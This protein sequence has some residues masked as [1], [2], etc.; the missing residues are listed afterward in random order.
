[1]K[2]SG[3]F[4]FGVFGILALVGICFLCLSIYAEKEINKPKFELPEGPPR[5]LRELPADK[6]EA[7]D[8]VSELYNSIISA[9]DAEATRHT[10]ISTKG[11]KK[12][13]LSAADSEVLSRVLER[14]Q[15]NIGSLYPKCENVLVSE[16]NDLPA[17]CFTKADVVDF[18]ASQGQ[19]DENGNTVDD[20]CYFITLTL[21]P[22]CVDKDAILY[23]DQ[24]KE[25]EKELSSVLRVTS[26]D[27]TVK[28]Y[29]ARF[30]INRFDDYIVHAELR[31]SLTIKAAVDFKDDFK[32][33]CSDTAQFE[34]PYEAADVL[35]FLRYGIRF[36]DDQIAVRK[37]DMK[38][39]PLEVRV[40]SQ[41]EKSDYTLEFD[42]SKDGIL[43]IDDDGVMT[44]LSAQT[45]PL[46]VT[47]TLNYDGHVY[48]DVLTVYATEL[49]VKTD[50][51]TG[52]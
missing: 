20:D 29:T 34:I 44:V 42:V 5:Q 24:R 12:T 51:Q 41:T 8:Y 26:L 16:L 17:L 28:G 23:S 36:T 6:D 39:L 18:T 1:M 40:N 22:D 13:Y 47:A 14:S 25:I 15:G 9:D 21:N 30:K 31:R 4:F 2:K 50:E 49:E 35:D 32:S 48:T 37:N 46:T 7:F 11:E 19:T 43:K 45:D 27:I 10:E 38:A 3:K 52:G 33:L